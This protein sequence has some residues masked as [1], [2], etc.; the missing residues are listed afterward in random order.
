MRRHHDAEQ[1][2]DQCRNRIERESIRSWFSVELL[3]IVRVDAPTSG[4]HVDSSV[5]PAP[6]GCGF[7]KHAEL[8][9]M[10]A[11][12]PMDN[13]ICSTY[14]ATTEEHN[15]D[16]DM[17]EILRIPLPT[18]G[19]EVLQEDIAGTVQPNDEGLGEFSRRHPGA[20]LANLGLA[21]LYLPCP[22][23][24]REAAHPAAKGEQS[25]PKEYAAFDEVSE[26]VE[27]ISAMLQL[28]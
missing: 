20:P 7:D 15:T 21:R 6:D 23:P 18:P 27:D 26:S 16:G 10:L 9:S 13:L 8:E 2:D 24:S 28:S 14:Q 17:L 5:K 3:L 22:T 12:Y 4:H 1:H 11:A 19:A 25:I